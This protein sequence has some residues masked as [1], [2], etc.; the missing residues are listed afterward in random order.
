MSTTVMERQETEEAVRAMKAIVGER[1]GRPDVLDLRDVTVLRHA[2][3]Q[4]RK[5]LA[6][7]SAGPMDSV[8]SL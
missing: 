5:H 4:A 1:Y 2:S 6:Q 3:A 8:V 7:R